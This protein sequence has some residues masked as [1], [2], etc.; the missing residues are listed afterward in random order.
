[1]L[2]YYESLTQEAMRREERALWTVKR[3]ELDEKR[4]AFI[5][6]DNLLIDQEL[7]SRKD[8]NIGTA[9]ENSPNVARYD[10]NTRPKRVHDQADKSHEN[11]QEQNLEAF[12]G[13]SKLEGIIKDFESS[14]KH[15]R[16]PSNVE[17]DSAAVIVMQNDYLQNE[18]SPSNFGNQ[19]LKASS[20][21]KV[22]A[23][24]HLGTEIR[25]NEKKIEKESKHAKERVEMK[26]LLYPDNPEDSDYPDDFNKVSNEQK[27]EKR[28]WEMDQI[29]SLPPRTNVKDILYPI[30]ESEGKTSP[31][32]STRGNE[33]KS[34]MKDLLYHYKPEGK[35]YYYY[36]YF[37]Q[38]K[39]CLLHLKEIYKRHWHFK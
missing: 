14:Q 32:I 27:N 21:E 33:P 25:T 22:S 39:Y 19:P 23:S 13:M 11:K 4:K 24:S 38:P 10:S 30:T 3:Y 18:Q 12:T 20:S 9:K 31:G 15:E 35:S 34:R 16:K 26:A 2:G 29:R 36:Y 6:N 1:M 5:A 28:F 8:S 7:I 17:H 37:I